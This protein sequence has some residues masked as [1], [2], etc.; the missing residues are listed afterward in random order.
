MLW[1]E[2]PDVQRRALAPRGLVVNRVQ[3]AEAHRGGARR[4]ERQV[5]A[6]DHSYADTYKLSQNC[7]IF[8]PKLCGA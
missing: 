5:K 3:E 4:I 1:S 8:G 7:Q 6:S 2:I